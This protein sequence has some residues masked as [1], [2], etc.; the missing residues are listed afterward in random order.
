MSLLELQHVGYRVGDTPILQDV[1]LKIDKQ[2]WVTIAGPSGSGK[3][4]LV[5]IIAS[6]LSKTS[7]ELRFAGQPIESYDPIAYRRR[8]SYAFQQ[9][10][11]FG[12][13]V[14]DNLAFP[15]QIRQE[16]FD[17]QR[18][19]TALEY[20]GLGEADLTKHVTDLSGG[21]RQRIALLRNVMIY[22]EV[23]ILDEV[24]AGLDA[25]NKAFVWN[26]IQHFN[27]D[28]HLTII[29]ITHDQSEIESAKRLVTIENGQIVG[30]AQ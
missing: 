24:T 22:P 20:V 17:Q 3:S 25:D 1:N 26:M 29:A 12:E 11:L 5:R 4:T 6:L 27:Q 21:Q 16:P 8:V 15:Y 10:T 28:D 2:E 7:G 9:P 19:I 18:A 13:T 23:L 14:A 30:G